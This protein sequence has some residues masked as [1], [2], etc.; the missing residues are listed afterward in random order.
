M[1]QISNLVMD[2]WILNL[3]CYQNLEV[4]ADIDFEKKVVAAVAL[5]IYDFVQNLNAYCY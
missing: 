2:H 4:S 1:V 5:E 3:L